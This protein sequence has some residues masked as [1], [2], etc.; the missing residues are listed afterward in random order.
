MR[1]A[2]DGCLLSEA[3]LL[4]GM[5]VWQ[6]LPDPFPAWGDKTTS[7]RHHPST[8]RMRQRLPS[9]IGGKEHLAGELVVERRVRWAIHHRPFHLGQV[10]HGTG[11]FQP[12]VDRLQ[13]LQGE[14]SMTFT[15]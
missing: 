8:G 7:H 11:V 13:A 4:E 15:A 14:A 5:K 9:V 12:T 1:E 10:E 6:Q 2:L 3:E